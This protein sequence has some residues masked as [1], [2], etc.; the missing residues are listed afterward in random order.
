LSS[1]VSEVIV[2]AQQAR[3]QVE[4]HGS[5]GLLGTQDALS[6]PSNLTTY[7]SKLILDP[8]AETIDATVAPASGHACGCRSAAAASRRCWCTR[9]VPTGT[10]CGSSRCERS[11]RPRR[12]RRMAAKRKKLGAKS[13]AAY[14]IAIRE[15]VASHTDTF[16]PIT[17][18]QWLGKLAAWRA[19]HRAVDAG[20][21]S[22]RGRSTLE[23]DRSMP[24]GFR[25]GGSR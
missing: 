23:S 24:S 21:Q 6:T 2:T 15:N 3:K 4:S 12:R 25:R 1:Q 18:G 14:F 19:E 16:G 8:Q 7:T 9:T 10:S 22:V 13:G 5:V 17:A 11:S 20:C